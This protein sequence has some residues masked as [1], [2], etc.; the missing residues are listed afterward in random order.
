MSGLKLKPAPT[1]LMLSTLAVPF[2]ISF[3]I[4]FLLMYFIVSLSKLVIVYVLRL[5]YSEEKPA[6]GLTDLN[7]YFKST[8]KVKHENEDIELDTK[9]FHNALEFKSVRVRECMIPRTEIVAV[10]EDEGL[11]K[12]RE[13]F[14]ESGHSKILVYKETIDDVTGYCH[15]SALF[16][17]PQKID[18]ILTPIII[19]PETTLA[20]ELMIRFINERKRRFM[21]FSLVLR[22]ASHRIAKRA[23]FVKICSVL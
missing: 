22:R 7:N 8:H 21:P 23:V 9:I 14:V 13:A 17:K 15:S 5:E 2:M 10:E 3:G 18:E 19:V 4:L 11:S 6:F 16:R 12:L 1:S 20:N